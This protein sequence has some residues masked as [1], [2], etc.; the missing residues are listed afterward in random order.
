MKT[1][2]TSRKI[3][4][5]GSLLAG[6]MLLLSPAIG[7]ALAEQNV[8]IYKNPGETAFVNVTNNNV[9]STFDILGAITN[10]SADANGTLNVGPLLPLT[11]VGVNGTTIENVVLLG[12]YTLNGNYLGNS[13]VSYYEVNA[14]SPTGYFLNDTQVNAVLG[15][16]TSVYLVT[17]YG[18]GD[19]VNLVNGWT[20]DIYSVVTPGRGVT[21]NVYTGV[22]SSTYAIQVGFNSTINISPLPNVNDTT[23]ASTNVFN[24]VYGD[25]SY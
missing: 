24:V 25:S 15:N 23:T 18:S 11:L 7:S 5:V 10:S 21:V 6:A 9:N 1:E 20:D 22:G 2:L 16:M 17:G 8:F 12:N 3:L 13:T 14:T 4:A 19:V